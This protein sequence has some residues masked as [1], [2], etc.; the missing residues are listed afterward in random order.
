MR[1]RKPAL[2]PNLVRKRLKNDDPF[3]TTYK[4][5]SHRSELN[6][7]KKRG[8][9]RK[10]KKTVRYTIFKYKNTLLLKRRKAILTG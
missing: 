5:G 9:G 2:R 10:G 6:K 4:I 1:T 8:G 7:Q 3:T